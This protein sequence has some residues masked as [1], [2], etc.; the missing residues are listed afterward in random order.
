[1]LSSPGFACVRYVG[2]AGAYGTQGGDFIPAPALFDLAFGSNWL[3]AHGKRKASVDRA[4]AL[5]ADTL[6]GGG[7]I[8]IM[9]GG[10]S[11]FS[12]AALGVALERTNVETTRARVH[13]IKHSDWN[14]EVTSPEALAFVRTNADYRKIPDGNATGNGTPGYRT[15]EAGLWHRIPVEG[16]AATMWKTARDLANAQNGVGYENTAIRAG[17]FDFSDTVE[18]AYVFGLEELDDAAAFL[19]HFLGPRQ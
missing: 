4:G 6:A 18:A 14:E 13:V 19:A 2:V 3:D 9:D 15:N 1:M 5:I 17:G 10:Q 8:W 12:A 7:H 16:H 11:D